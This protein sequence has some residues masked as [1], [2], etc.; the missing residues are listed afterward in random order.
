[1]DFFRQQLQHSDRTNLSSSNNQSIFPLQSICESFQVE[2]SETRW[3]SDVY[4]CMNYNSFVPKLN[5]RV[6]NMGRCVSKLCQVELGF[7]CLTRRASLL[8]S[9]EK[10][11]CPAGCLV[12]SVWRKK[13]TFGYWISR[14]KLW[15]PWV[16]VWWRVRAGGN[17]AVEEN[18]DPM[19]GRMK[20]RVSVHTE[21][22]I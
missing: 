13:K 18:F 2:T 6:A 12:V 1:M 21:R 15:I 20:E 19:S 14:F 22:T 9:G 11:S 7:S 5:F 10:I 4:I 8:W 16:A 17:L 3:S